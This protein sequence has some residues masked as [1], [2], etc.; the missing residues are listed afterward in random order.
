MPFKHLFFLTAAFCASLH[1]GK[2]IQWMEGSRLALAH[3][4]LWHEYDEATLSTA[5]RNRPFLSLPEGYFTL[6]IQA[7]N[8]FLDPG[9][10]LSQVLFQ[11]GNRDTSNVQ[12]LVSALKDAGVPLQNL[13][14]VVLLTCF[15]GRNPL[16]GGVSLAKAISNRLNVP[17]LASTG[18]VEPR[19]VL[20]LNSE[21]REPTTHFALIS[22]SQQKGETRQSPWVL[23][24]PSGE[25]GEGKSVLNQTKCLLDQMQEEAS[26]SRLISGDL[27]PHL[28]PATVQEIEILSK[29][30]LDMRTA[31]RVQ[32]EWR[33]LGLRLQDRSVTVLHLDPS[34]GPKHRNELLAGIRSAIQKNPHSTGYVI[35]NLSPWHWVEGTE[36]IAQY[37]SNWSR[38]VVFTPTPKTSTN[39]APVLDYTQW[40]AYTPRYTQETYFEDEIQG[41]IRELG[42]AFGTEE[43]RPKVAGQ[44]L[45]LARCARKIWDAAFRSR[46][47]PE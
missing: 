32:N 20:A 7:G 27:R 39:G 31:N 29:R 8:G 6:V 47:V 33:R 30:P 1:A 3:P 22:L 38:Q 13:K 24:E 17:V 46:G 28:G 15:G 35:A 2:A 19:L 12:D 34:Y 16:Q 9:G 26:Q 37:V 14:G 44:A 11:L 45:G 5:F 43:A 42:A 18:R 25:N 21:S 4:D 41:V 40:M 36:P 10:D 23:E